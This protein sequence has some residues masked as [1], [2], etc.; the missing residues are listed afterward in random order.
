[1]SDVVPLPTTGELVGSGTEWTER[2]T[3]SVMNTF[4]PPRRVLV[5]GEGVHVWDADGRRY[6]DLLGGIAVNVLGHAHPTLTAAVSAQLGT[7]GQVSNFFASPV[8]V[9]LAERLV[10]LAG[11]DAGSRVFFANSGTEA[12]EAAFKMARR[13]GRPRVLALEGAFHGRT[14]GALALTHK[15]AYREPFE[16]LPGGVEFVPF[17]DAAALEAAMSDDVAAIVLEPVQGEAG[18]RPLPPGYLAHARAL[19]DRHGALLVLDEIQT[20]VGRTGAWFAHQLPELGGGVRPDVVTLA[21][22]LG[23]GIPI[24]AVVALSER[25]ATLLGPGQHGT[26]FGGNPVAAVAA[27]TTLGVIERDGLLARVR[28]VGGRLA[29]ALRTV[30]PLVTEV[31]AAGLLVAAELAAPVA[32]RVADEALAAGWIVNPVTPSALR[33]APPLV[34]TWDQVAGF[35]DWLAALPAREL[36]TE[37]DH[38]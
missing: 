8:Q 2:Y 29:D 38:A 19:A 21:K 12:N 6:T 30:T 14:M 31:R 33:L 28:E 15:A 27:L 37:G 11:G 3:R 22:G 7:L 17:G 20:G 34:L 36:L 4:G 10:A 26:T 18:V 16:P 24:G 35:V 23:G 32:A 9:A 5:R 1:M 13:T 25:A